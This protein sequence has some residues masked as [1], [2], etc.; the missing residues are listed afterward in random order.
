MEILLGK[1][2]NIFNGSEITM[3]E[4]K[5]KFVGTVSIGTLVLFIY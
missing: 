2:E 5:M 3:K 1:S 4:N